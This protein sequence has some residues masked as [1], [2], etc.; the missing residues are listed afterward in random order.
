MFPELDI[1][2]GSKP[3]RPNDLIKK[4]LPKNLTT[5][6]PFLFLQKMHCHNSM[7]ESNPQSESVTSN[8]K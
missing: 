8:K 1:E 3:N 7:A 4:T 2:V 6:S 5:H